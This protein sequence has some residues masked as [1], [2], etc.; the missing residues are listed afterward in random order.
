MAALSGAIHCQILL[1]KLDEAKQQ[2]DFLEEVQST[3]GKS[4][5][6]CHLSAMLCMKQHQGANVILPL[7][8]ETAHMH[9]QAVKGIP[10]GAH[11][12]RVLNPDFILQVMSNCV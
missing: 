2:L 1:G 8:E 9:F 4:A 3:I 12:F 7:L 10:L 11:Y 5:E 6:V